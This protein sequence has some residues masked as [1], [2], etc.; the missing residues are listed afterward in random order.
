MA[1]YKEEIKRGFTDFDDSFGI[2]SAQV[3]DSGNVVF[4]VGT[5]VVDEPFT[6]HLTP[7]EQS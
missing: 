1:S 4:V 3:E 5:E 7:E 2:E 6:I